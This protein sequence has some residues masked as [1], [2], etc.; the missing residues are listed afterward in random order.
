MGS[1]VLLLFLYGYFHSFYSIA[2]PA[3]ISSF[4]NIRAS[5]SP[6]EL[7]ICVVDSTGTKFLNIASTVTTPLCT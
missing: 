1:N 3:S 6:V 4:S 5:D 2:L 7:P